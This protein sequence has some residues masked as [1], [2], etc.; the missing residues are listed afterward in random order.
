MEKK[1]F[2]EHKEEKHR[3][4]ECKI[5]D[6]KS[7]SRFGLNQHNKQAHPEQMQEMDLEKAQCSGKRKL[8]SVVDRLTNKTTGN[9]ITT[10][11]GFMV[12]EKDGEIEDAPESQ[13]NLK[14]R[15]LSERLQDP[16]KVKD[17]SKQVNVNSFRSQILTLKKKVSRMQREVGTEPDYVI[18]MK[19][20]LQ[21]PH[22]SN[23]A[24]SAG[25]YLVFGEGAIKQK[26]VKS[27]IKFDDKKMFLMANN[28]N[29]D[30]EKISKKAPVGEEVQKTKKRTTEEKNVRIKPRKVAT[31]G[32]SFV[33][34][35]S[36]S[37]DSSASSAEDS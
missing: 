9:T 11:A 6:K 22:T 34:P 24:A 19:N 5:C 16:I 36:S 7:S 35:S 33:D 2:V 4:Y 26:L 12:V 31:P 29:F 3:V 25:K 32:F 18:L 13:I 1:S 27:G 10:T 17:R 23:P 37:E 30:E 28:H 21:D 8:D 15:K 14:R 20:N